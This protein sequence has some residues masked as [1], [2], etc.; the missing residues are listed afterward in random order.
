MR[1]H[2]FS[3]EA[4]ALSPMGKE[5][6][7]VQISGCGSEHSREPRKS[8]TPVFDWTPLCLSSTTAG[9]FWSE[10]SWPYF[11]RWQD[12]PY[13]VWRCSTGERLVLDLERG[14]FVTE[15]QQAEPSLTALFIREERNGA[16]SLLEE[17]SK[18][19]PDISEFLARK[20]TEKESGSAAE[21]LK[22]KLFLV[23]SALNLIR[24]HRMVECTP[25]LRDWEILNCPSW[26]TSSHALMGWSI[27]EQR[28]RPLIHH[29]LRLLGME[30]LGY[31]AYTFRSHREEYYTVPE[32]IPNRHERLKKINDSMPAEEVLLAVGSPDFAFTQSREESKR[33]IWSENWEYDF[34]ESGCWK[35]LRLVWEDRN[36]TSRMVRLQE[37][38]GGVNRE[39]K[40]LSG[41]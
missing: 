9:L 34:V 30:P 2:G 28:F 1:T 29:T 10:N 15:A 24:V 32:H 3:P 33:F 13:F 11:C 31:S 6:I 20:D 27:Q 7:R 21:D 19:M 18:R 23:K 16:Y 17:L 25:F 36:D 35:T 4:I 26:Q 41:F 22:E 5:K 37:E 8:K 39:N 12:S 38:L 14:R 40:L